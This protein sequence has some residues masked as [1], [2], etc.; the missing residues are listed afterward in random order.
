MG[1]GKGRQVNSMRAYNLSSCNNT[2]APPG[3]VTWRLASPGA[4]G[5][6]AL[7]GVDDG[8]RGGWGEG[9]RGLAEAVGALRFN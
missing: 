6:C 2:C 1:I 3:G 4:I 5:A 7:D 8:K 9:G